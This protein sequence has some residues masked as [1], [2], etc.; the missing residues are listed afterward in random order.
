[1]D[2][3]DNDAALA[4]FQELERWQQ[5]IDRARQHDADALDKWLDDFS[6]FMTTHDRSNDYGL[7]RIQHPL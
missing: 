4:N 6:R 3:D 1:M 2:A 5:E 7:V